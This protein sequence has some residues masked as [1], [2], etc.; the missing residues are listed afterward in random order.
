MERIREHKS[1]EIQKIEQHKLIVKNSIEKQLCKNNM[2]KEQHKKSIEVVLNDIKN[3]RLSNYEF[4]I[5][6]RAEN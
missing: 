3:K 6:K 2:E 4:M 1:L 5:R